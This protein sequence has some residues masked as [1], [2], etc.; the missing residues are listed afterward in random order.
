[1]VYV[2]IWESKNRGL[3]KEQKTKIRQTTE[4]ERGQRQER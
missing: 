1:M 4:R 3:R 2:G